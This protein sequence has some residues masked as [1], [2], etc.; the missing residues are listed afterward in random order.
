MFKGKSNDWHQ[1]Y[2]HLEA[3]IINTLVEAKVCLVDHF[4]EASDQMSL[5]ILYLLK[6]NSLLSCSLNSLV[7]HYGQEEVIYIVFDT[8]FLLLSQKYLR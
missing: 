1:E 6:L 5:Y 2:H 8:E 3:V 4:L 7:L